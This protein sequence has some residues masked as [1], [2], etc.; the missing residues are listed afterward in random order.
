MKRVNLVHDV[1]D[2]LYVQ[3]HPQILGML[4]KSCFL[5][6]GAQGAPGKYM[7]RHGSPIVDSHKIE[8]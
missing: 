2:I 4:I 7:F 1:T 8:Y 3:I 5:L 6:A